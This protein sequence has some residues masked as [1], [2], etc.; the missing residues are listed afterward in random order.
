MEGDLTGDYG[1]EGGF[2]YGELGM[3]SAKDDASAS[4]A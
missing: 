3:L 4:F 1:I 2:L